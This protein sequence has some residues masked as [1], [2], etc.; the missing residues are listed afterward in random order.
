MTD[1]RTWLALAIITGGGVLL[2][3]LAPVLTPFLISALLAYMGDPLVD[4]LEAKKVTRTVAVTI[5]FSGFILFTLLLLLILIPLIESQIGTFVAKVPL[6]ID[7]LQGT[8]LPWLQ[9][10]LALTEIPD[11]SQLKQAIQSHW[12][13]AGGVMVNVVGSVSRSGGALLE[14]VANMVLIPVIS[15][16]LLRDWDILIKNIHDL[17][18][19][20]IESVVVKLSSEANEVLGEFVRGQLLVML[21]LGVVYSLG[22]WT[23]GLDYAVLIGMIAGVVSFV[24]YLGMIIGVTLA[25]IAGLFQ[26]H[27]ITALWPLIIVFGIG[28]VLESFVLT[29]YFVGDRI[30]LH[31][32]AVIFAIAAFGQLFGFVGILVALPAAAVVMVLLRHAHV[33]YRNSDLYG[34]AQA[35][36]K[37]ANDPVDC[38]D[39]C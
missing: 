6:Y 15:F 14:L 37:N 16:Y 10:R 33:E 24:P 38:G 31:P 9:A 11:I 17:L 34:E 39:G 12:Q 8:A 30:G 23:M 3:L 1:T 28:Q 26:F 13:Q 19:R 25:V 21:A 18:P 5:V 4:K 29:P 36:D 32:V 22:L 7:W 35:A 2:Y 27:D 20:T